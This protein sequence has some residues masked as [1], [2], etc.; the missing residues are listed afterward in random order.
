MVV[1]GEYPE[2]YEKLL[3]DT[4]EETIYSD[5][6]MEEIVSI[7]EYF[8]YDNAKILISGKGVLESD[9]FDEDS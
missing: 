2:R 8:T 4:Y 1:L 6:D 3:I 7:L 5:Y 9:V